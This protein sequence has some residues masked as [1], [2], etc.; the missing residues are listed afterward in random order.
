MESTFFS[1]LEILV[2]IFILSFRV[3]LKINHFFIVVCLTV[4]YAA[5]NGGFLVGFVN[6]NKIHFYTF[7]AKLDAYTPRGV[8][9]LHAFALFS[10]HLQ[11]T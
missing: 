5:F 10:S 6:P 3:L 4:P 8:S 1:Y 11:T 7:L 2:F 9:H